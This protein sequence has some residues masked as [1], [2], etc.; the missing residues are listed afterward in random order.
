MEKSM[1]IKT[2]LEGLYDYNYWANQRY[3]KTAESLT[4]EQFLRE[5]GNNWDSIHGTLLHMM[6][7]ET[8]WLKRWQGDAPK[9]DFSPNDFPTL[10]SIQENWAELE[11]RMRSFLADQNEQSLQEDTVCTGYN[12]GTFHLLLWQMMM[13]VPNHNT[14]HRSELA[15]MFALLNVPHPEDEV[16]KF[17][18]IQSGQRNG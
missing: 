3:L 12:G 14:H 15:A 13:H 9:K 10:M 6:N 2:Y 1:S 17:F 16:V 8:I 7:T 5:Q 18:L 11:K 4:E